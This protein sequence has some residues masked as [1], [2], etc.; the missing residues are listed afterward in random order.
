MN[1]LLT[2]FLYL[3]LSIR[4][5]AAAPAQV[6]VVHAGQTRAFAIESEISG[7]YY[8]TA[9]LAH[10]ASTGERA[11]VKLFRPHHSAQGMLDT[12]AKEVEVLS[13][14][15][16]RHAKLFPKVFGAGHS[17]EGV[18]AAAMAME[19]IDAPHVLG[20]GPWPAQRA[21]RIVRRVLDGL[22]DLHAAGWLHRDLRERNILVAE[23]GRSNTTRVVDLGEA[24][25][26]DGKH[27]SLTD[28]KGAAEL[29]LGLVSGM[30]PDGA[31][32]IVW[33]PAALEIARGIHALDG[34][35][36]L[37]TVISNALDGHYATAAELR[38]ALQP[39]TKR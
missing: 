5:V 3:L 16:G 29:L 39:F 4:L 22:T 15:K 24:I 17:I 27:T 36:D 25:R 33:Q 32:N 9:H 19:H 11:V 26:I 31:S 6:Q 7:G 13:S 20:R 37:G 21:V 35:T 18:P 30:R 2:S 23:S 12:Y 14:I 38:A 34:S 1:K 10:D 8:S 28:V